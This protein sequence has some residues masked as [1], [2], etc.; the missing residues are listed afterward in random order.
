MEWPRS[1]GPCECWA[2]YQNLPLD[3]RLTTYTRNLGHSPRKPH[4]PLLYRAGGSGARGR[5]VLR[6]DQGQPGSPEADAI[7]ASSV[8]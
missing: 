6:K 7:R 1:P 4:P 5:P 2:A 8:A 3:S